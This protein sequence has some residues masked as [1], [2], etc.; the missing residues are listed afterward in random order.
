M[1]MHIVLPN[2]APE[3]DLYAASGETEFDDE[4]F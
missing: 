2:M 4:L 1:Y 3:S